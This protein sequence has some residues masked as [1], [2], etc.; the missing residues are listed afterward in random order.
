MLRV[1]KNN[2]KGF[3][4]SELL[5]VVAIVGVLVA[6]SIPI[7]TDSEKKPRTQYVPRIEEVC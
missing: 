5:V 2:R 6:V 7:F 4:I 1:N 3:T